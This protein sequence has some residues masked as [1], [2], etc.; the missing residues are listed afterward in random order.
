M[1]SLSSR[2][3]DQMTDQ[4]VFAN[5]CGRLA[6]AAIGSGAISRKALKLSP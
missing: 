3:V 4:A 1:A 2:I 6:H 5:D